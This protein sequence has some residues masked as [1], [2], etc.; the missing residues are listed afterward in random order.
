[1]LNLTSKYLR[2]TRQNIKSKSCISLSADSSALAIKN[3]FPRQYYLVGLTIFTS[4]GPQLFRNFKAPSMSEH[5]ADLF[6]KSTL[7]K[8]SVVKYV[9]IN[10]SFCKSNH[11]TLSCN[12]QFCLFC[13]CHSY[14][15]DTRLSHYSSFSGRSDQTFQ[16]L[17]RV[18]IRQTI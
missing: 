13:A 4:M 6:Q 7:K 5:M 1:M 16:T 11:T 15:R 8:T 10:W 9:Q 3:L 17:V 14:H 2:S 12:L 18:L